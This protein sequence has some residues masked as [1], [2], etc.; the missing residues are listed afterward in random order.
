MSVETIFGLILLPLLILLFIFAGFQVAFGFIAVVELLSVVLQVGLFF[1]TRN[2][3]F[4]LLALALGLIFVFALVL[5]LVGLDG[6]RQ[7][8]RSLAPLV[9]AAS[10]IVIYV[11]ANKKV[12]W[13]TREIL[14]LS[15]MPVTGVE[16]GFTERPMPAGKIEATDLELK[17]FAAFLRQNQIAIP[18][19]DGEAV[20]LSLTSNY[21]KQIGLKS[22]YE[23][24]SWVRIESNG[25]VSASISKDQY[26]KFRD[27]FSFDQLCRSLG[28]LFISF[29]EMYRNG[30]GKKVIERCDSLGLNP[31]I[32]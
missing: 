11:I 28:A 18:Y 20:I 23:D 17:S 25:Q 29:F 32:E 4:L 13:R 31:F 22:G 24:E 9:L 12:K 10:I 19:T 26:W 30:E 1:R 2:P 7:G 27:R 8:Y 21:W 3:H 16:N 6:A 5:A 15:A 14:E